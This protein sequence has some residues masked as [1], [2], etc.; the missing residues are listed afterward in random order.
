MGKQIER[1]YLNG[2]SRLKPDQRHFLT[3]PNA[4]LVP[5]A[6]KQGKDGFTLTFDTE[7]LVPF[8]MMR[9]VEEATEI[10]R[11]LAN[12]AA[13]QSLQQEY[14]FIL[15]PD[16]LM[17]DINLV[18]RIL[19]RDA[20]DGPQPFVEMYKALIGT[21]VLPT[22]T[23]QDFLN[24][25]EDFYGKNQF[26]ASIRDLKTVEEIETTLLDKY[27]A[28]RERDQ[29]KLV[30]V[31]KSTLKFSRIFMPILA[32]LTV[33]ALVAAGWLFFYRFP[34]DEAVTAAY[35]FYEQYD[36]YN[37]QKQLAPYTL[38]QIPYDVKYILARSYIYTDAIL[39]QQYRENV[40]ET[41]DTNTDERQLNYWIEVGREQYRNAIDYAEQLQ[42]DPLLL[43]ALVL[44]R[45]WTEKDTEL[46]GADKTAL[47]TEL[48]ARIKQMDE[49]KKAREKAEEEAKQQEEQQTQ[50]D[51]EEQEQND[52][53]D[54]N[55]SENAESNS[56]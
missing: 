5:C 37:V 47:L 36:Y 43:Y 27:F 16:N 14:A 26:L 22:Y 38:E 17:I 50:N 10:Y 42:D 1:T 46:S 33:L 19:E 51:E 6:L 39:E 21:T 54:S 45:D 56:Q 12:I 23:Y 29:K 28:C 41:I 24:G 18:P 34:F 2:E 30:R 49:A 13:F 32:L 3:Y 15:S 8:T 52:E 25:G 20:E 53:E 7:G 35:A 9:E 44:Y 55:S 11:A 31:R 40:L 48:D 4:H